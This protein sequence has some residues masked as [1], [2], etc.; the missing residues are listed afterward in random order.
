MFEVSNYLGRDLEHT[1]KCCNDSEKGNNSS[2]CLTTHHTERR[3]CT[4]V[5]CQGRQD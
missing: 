3:V 2:K 4:N 1:A 5:G